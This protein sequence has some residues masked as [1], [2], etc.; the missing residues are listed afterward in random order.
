MARPPI[1]LLV[2]GS[3]PTD[4][5]GNL[6][7]A[8][9]RHDALRPLAES[10]AVNG[11]ASLRFD[12]R[13]VGGTASARIP[14]LDMRFQTFAWDVADWISF[15]AR[16]GPFGPLTVFLASI[17]NYL[18][19]WMH[20]SPADELS[21]LDGPCLVI[22]GRHDAQVPPAN[23]DTL[24]KAQP[25]CVRATIDRMTHTLKQGPADLA[26]QGPMYLDPSLPLAPGLVTSM[27]DFIHLITDTAP[28]S[29]TVNSTGAPRILMDRPLDAPRNESPVLLDG[30]YLGTFGSATLYGAQVDS[31]ATKRLTSGDEAWRYGPAARRCGVLLLRTY[32]SH[33]AD[34]AEIVAAVLKAETLRHRPARTALIDLADSS[35]EVRG[36]S[37][38]LRS[39]IR[40]RGVAVTEQVEVGDD[41]VRVAPSAI[42]ITRGTRSGD[43]AQL[44]ARSRWTTRTVAGTTSCRTTSSV[45]TSD[46]VAHANGAWRAVPNEVAVPTESSCVA[47]PPDERDAGAR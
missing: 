9:G 31:I 5:D 28:S 33:A 32:A 14:E 35:S 30:R 40:K 16:R 37:P 2:G 10:L 19:S 3:G 17:H 44:Q 29:C 23:A 25:G 22:H 6:L 7:G 15:I 24:M 1:V 26:S 36:M 21:V 4:R 13:G 38:L 20:F 34:T 27:L 8:P 47:I 41:T 46:T 45:T 18:S 43:V 42:V 39:E 12:K 11:I